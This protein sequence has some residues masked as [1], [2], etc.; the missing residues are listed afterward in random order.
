MVIDWVK[1][2][3]EQESDTIQYSG[4][5]T[6]WYGLAKMATKGGEAALRKKNEVSVRYGE[7]KALQG[8]RFSGQWPYKVAFRRKT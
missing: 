8:G 5:V 6:Q 3:R 1:A 7:F 2:V 4:M